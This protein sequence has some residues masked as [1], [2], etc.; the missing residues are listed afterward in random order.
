[1]L[2]HQHATTNMFVFDFDGTLLDSNK[3][4]RSAYFEVLGNCIESKVTMSNILENIQGDRYAV[5]QA[6]VSESKIESNIE[7]Q[8]AAYVENYSNIVKAKLKY[9]K[10]IE[11]ALALLDYL[12]Q[13]KL[14]CALS[15]ATPL[16]YLR[17]TIEHLDW[18]HYFTDIFGS[19][20]TKISSLHYLQGKYDLN[21]ND[22]IVIGDG[23]DDQYAAL[24]FGC[25]FLPVNDARGVKDCS[26]VYSMLELLCLLKKNKLF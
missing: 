10:P 12:K 17:E 9:A 4:K 25:K 19:P 5:W 2:T 8:V 16:I 18:E 3:I 14:R 20:N 6:Y 15:S 21:K 24:K 23:K 26:K 13:K 11:G 7:G 22:L 1:M